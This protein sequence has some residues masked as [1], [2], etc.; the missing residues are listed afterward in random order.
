[1]ST[2]RAT[3]EAVDWLLRLESAQAGDAHTQAFER[4]LAQG[5]AQASAW[6]RV[7]ALFSAPLANLAAVEARSPGQLQLA[8]H[9]LG[10]P[11]ARRR[12]L[13][14]GLAALLLSAAG[15]S[16]GNRA[17]PL[18]QLLADLHTATG[19]RLDRSL[20]DGSHLQLDARSAADCLFNLGQRTIRLREGA[21]HLRVAAG[22]D[23]PLTLECRDGRLHCQDGQLVLRQLHNSSLLSVIA[24]QVRVQS[25]AT[26]A[27]WVEAGQVLRFNH[28]ASALEAPSIWS[29]AYWIDG[30]AELR[31]EP[32]G[33][34]VE[35]LR[36]YHAGWLRISPEAARLRTY[37]SFPLDDLPRTL[38]ALEETLPVRIQQA[39][40]WFVHIDLNNA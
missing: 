22:A 34:L 17:T 25:R 7:N 28:H 19:Q 31:D 10:Q 21:L 38:K 37:G 8:S 30:R 36:P 4:W 16:L 20:P 29:R 2:D 12:L 11:V 6:Q 15:L 40:G 23:R 26:A 9:T 5:A 1:M 32:L 27:Q 3:R 35:V 18:A 39:A 33:E 24:G 13:S 14:G